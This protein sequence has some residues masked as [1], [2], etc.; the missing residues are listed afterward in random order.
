MAV[1]KIRQKLASSR[2]EKQ[3]REDT[4]KMKE[5]DETTV[6]WNGM[7]ERDVGSTYNCYYS[8]TEL[9]S[10]SVGFF[11]AGLAPAFGVEAPAGAAPAVEV[12]AN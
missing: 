4:A 2:H 6:E 12:A 1:N 8:S 5:A 11:R 3:R 9:N 7:E 10:R